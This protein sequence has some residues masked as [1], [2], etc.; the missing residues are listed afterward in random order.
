MDATVSV[1]HSFR[2]CDAILGVRV[3][4]Y[5]NRYIWKTQIVDVENPTT[6]RSK[7]FSGERSKAVMAGRAWLAHNRTSVP[8]HLGFM[9]KQ[10]WRQLIEMLLTVAKST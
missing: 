8:P 4:K 7:D 1:T 6:K 5:C 10:R 9:L 3:T 2:Q